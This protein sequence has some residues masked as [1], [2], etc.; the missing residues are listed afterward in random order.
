MSSFKQLCEEYFGTTDLYEVLGLQREASE[1]EIKK[2][3]HKISLLV[4]PDRVDESQKSVATEKFKVL[5]K[6]HSVLQDK[7][8]RQCYD[9]TGEIDEENDSDFNWMDYWR[10]MFKKIEIKDIE[11][12]EK[13][14]IG[15]DIELRDI[16]KAYVGTRGNMDLMLEMIPFSN[17][18]SEPRI[19]EIVRKMIDDDEVEEYPGFFDEPKRKKNRRRNK[20]EEEK[21]M[22]EMIDVKALE[23]EIEVNS[24]KRIKGFGDLVA[25]LEAK[26]GDGKKRKSLT[27]TPTPTKRRSSRA[28]K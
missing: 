13:E 4:H 28:K 16:K 17:C 20:W 18:D 3:Y 5:G 8:K 15:S 10:A 1:K 19:Q 11:N 27:N 21:K 25:N 14:Y 22:A 23:R 6:I 9:G 26:Y 2:A 7:D 12:H 24:E